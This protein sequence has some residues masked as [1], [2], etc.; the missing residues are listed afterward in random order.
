M[1]SGKLL[2]RDFAEDNPFEH[3]RKE[4]FQAVELWDWMIKFAILLF[5]IDVGIRRIQIDSKEWKQWIS[6]SKRMLTFWRQSKASLPQEQQL[7]LL[8][9]KRNKTRM[10][11]KQ[12]QH[13]KED[14]IDIKLFQSKE[15]ANDKS[16]SK[17]SITSSTDKLKV[18]E[19]KVE[20]SSTTSRL[21]AAKRNALRKKK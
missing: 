9:A 7:N 12:K 4:T 11:L 19:P 17:N 8:L 21:L 10:K 6:K 1:G 5:P 18:T 13:I 14:D 3:D 16:L 15:S 2:K 20:E